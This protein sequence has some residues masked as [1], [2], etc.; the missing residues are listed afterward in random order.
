MKKVNLYEN[1]VYL[2]IIRKAAALPLPWEML[3]GRSVVI[4]GATGLIGRCMIDLL[5]YKNQEE[6][7]A[8]RIYAISR[9]EKSARERLRENYFESELFQFI[10]HDIRQPFRPTDIFDVDYIMHLAS[11]THPRAYAEE[12]VETIITNISGTYNLLEFSAE[13]HARRI[14]FLSSVEIY[15]ENRG[16]VERF[17][18]DYMGYLDSNT[19]RAGYPESKRCG[20]AL[21]QAYITE[22]GLD[23]VIPRLPR[24]YGPTMLED[25]SK[26][27]AQFIR[28]AVCKQDVILKSEGSQQ[29]SF[30]HVI[31]AVSGILAV[32]LSGKKGEAYNIADSGNDITLK[33]M[34]EMIARN[35]GTSVRYDIPDEAEQRG[36]STATKAMLDGEKISGLGWKPLFTVEE[37]IR[38]T[39]EIL[40]GNRT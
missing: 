23:I 6:G 1:A 8:C 22:K 7:L 40:M 30:L 35:A 33:D 14:V 9:N 25:D 32:M 16:D 31:D 2:D 19:M 12:P 27:A 28:R 10:R 18:E 15:G 24:V 36:Y 29:Y 26:A 5:M 38:N 39:L 3:K 4:V 37:G 17:S 34:A 20:E 13:H 11:K 21:C